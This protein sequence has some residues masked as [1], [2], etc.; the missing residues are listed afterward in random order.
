MK[1]IKH[2]AVFFFILM[3]TGCRPEPDMD[4][5]ALLDYSF[6]INGESYQ[7]K[8]AFEGANVQYLMARARKKHECPTETIWISLSMVVFKGGLLRMDF[9][10]PGLEGQYKVGSSRSLTNLCELKLL[11]FIV[12]LIQVWGFVLGE[13]SEIKGFY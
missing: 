5:L 3:A 7:Q 1:N 9:S 6:D 10:I 13:V 4:Q 8:I 2:F 12:L 11:G